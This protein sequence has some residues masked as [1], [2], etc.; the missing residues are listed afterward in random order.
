MSFF[1]R[2]ADWVAEFVAT[3]YFFSFC[4]LLVL[5]WGPSLPVFGNVDTWQLVINT[6]TTIVTFLLVALLHNTQH[7]FEEATNRRLQVIMAKLGVED[8]VKDEGQK[9]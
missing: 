5:V 2:F 4:V 9:T 7:R 1:D 8:P 3:A 6:A